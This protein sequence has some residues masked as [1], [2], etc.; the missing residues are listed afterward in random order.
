MFRLLKYNF[1]ERY[2]VFLG[3]M[4]IIIIF[5]ILSINLEKKIAAIFI[6]ICFLLC[7]AAFIVLLVYSI[8]LFGRDMYSERGYLTYTLP[9]KGS[10]ILGSK[11]I[12]SAF[13]YIALYVVGYFSALIFLNK[14]HLIDK[15]RNYVYLENI[16]GYGIIFYTFSFISL[17]IYIYFSISLSKSFIKG[18]GLS[19]FIAFII[20]MVTNVGISFLDIG[21]RFLIKTGN[22]HMERLIFTSKMVNKL[23]AEDARMMSSGFDVFNIVSMTFEISVVIILFA[24]TS[25]LLDKKVDL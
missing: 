7:F 13:E 14:M 21:I 5:D 1:K 9:L 6:I 25:Y 18:K 20:F 10:S 22:L 3:L 19:K 8:A 17:L 4:A 16:F 24:V 2:R 23:N 15:V 11:L 12:V